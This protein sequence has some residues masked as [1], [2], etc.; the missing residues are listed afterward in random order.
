MEEM[1]LTEREGVPFLEFAHFKESGLVSHGFSTRHGGVS[2][3]PFDTLNLGLGRGD[4]P[5][6]V[7]ENF[8]RIC[9]ALE[10]PPRSLVFSDQVHGSGLLE[11][12]L[13]DRGKGLFRESDIRNVDGLMTDSPGVALATFYADCVPL[14]FLDPAHKAVALSHAGWR[15]TVDGIGP[16]TVAAMAKRFQSVP[17]ELLV[18]IGPSIGPCC[19]QVSEEVVDA[20]KRL[21][22]PDMLERIAKPEGNGK[23][24]IDLW[25]ANR[26]LLEDSGVLPGNI[27][28]AHLC[29]KCNGKDFFSHR[30]MGSNRGSLAA[31]LALKEGGAR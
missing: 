27:H 30:A 13:G 9:K 25:L 22:S 18:G 26:M 21:F 6:H 23:H 1:L 4:D 8:T 14:F 31:I 17:G 2:P 10:I 28:G 16:K 11:V 12:G 24:R 15:G 20:F 29:T 19:F 5:A 3:S 7:V